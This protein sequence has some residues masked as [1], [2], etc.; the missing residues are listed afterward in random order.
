MSSIATELAELLSTVQRPGDFF[1]SGTIEL[2]AP[3]LEVDGVGVVALP[4]LAMQAE[5]LVAVAERAP[6]G[7][8]AETVIDT[9]VRRT[10]Q[11][12]ADRVR[13]GGKHWTATL[14]AILARV[15]EGLGVNEPI[16]AE[17]YKLLVYDQGSF[18][19]NHRDT[20]KAP[21]MF[22]TLVVVLPSVSTGGDLV[23][24]H[25]GREVRL[26]L[27]CEDPAEAAFAAFYA[28][29]V[30][31][32]LPVTAGCRLTLVYNLLRRGKGPMPKPPSYAS[33]QA[34]AA[35]LLQ[36]WAASKRSSDGD[37]PE[38]LIYLLEHAYTSAELG[39]A[40]LKGVDAAV[41]GVLVSA[42]EQSGCDIHLA[43]L[44]IQESGAAEY[45]DNY[46]S[47]RSRHSEPD[48]EAGE[49][50]DR[51]EAL[52]DWRRPD[53][54]RSP[55]GELPVEDDEA[56]PDALEE[57][58]PDEEEFHEAAGNEGASFDRT[59]RR[60]ALVLWPRDRTFAVLNQAGLDATLPLLSDLAERW[61]ASGENN[62]SSLWREAYELSGHMLST[63]PNQRW[64]REHANAPSE[65]T[66]MLTPL[67]RLG[68]TARLDAF[69]ADIAPGGLQDKRDNDAI[70]AALARLSPDRTVVLIERI[71]AGAAATS[72][73]ACGDLLARAVAARSSSDRAGFVGAAKTLI[74][75]LPGDPARSVPRPP[76]QHANARME[77]GFIVDLLAA[78]GGIDEN[79]AEHAA[80]Y[81][82]AWPKTY[83]LDGILIP[84]IRRLVESIKT[85]GSA[86]VERL[87]AACVDHLRARIAEPLE[88]PKDW[89]RE[90]ALSCRCTR[91]TELSRYLA[92]PDR[93]TW[94]FKAP[95]SDRRHVEDII[96]KD[97]CDLDATTDRR[98]RPYALVCT[99]NQASYD[100][101]VKQRKSDEG[102]LAALNLR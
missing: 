73:A 97:R 44:T 77:P 14:N 71:I 95:E 22:A 23:V 89:V 20:E 60:A 31:E 58:E 17:L 86:A 38:K 3:R 88:L 47:R 68:D 85:K 45:V 35:A 4:L 67:T 2:P 74:D 64:Y 9:D 66:R 51:H 10:W 18:F 79:L 33:E 61:A 43:L 102:N 39:F 82:L 1:A 49:V 99:K 92:D 53:G 8:G 80:D 83:S 70:F 101:R 100:R 6:Y 24:R 76:W 65:A 11:I 55:L 36:S 16:A 26:D 12:G 13:I 98:G 52:S 19:V 48:L 42:A 29:C 54:S 28:D 30:H 57:M 78:L 5:Q 87:R 56:P 40:A 37:T 50:F 94:I 75:A 59:Y 27:N 41:A 90:N 91:C 34:Q 21:G 62:Q 15:A 84:A 7:R 93:R 32:V 46:G 69:L 81:I 72:L 25:K 63:W 96:K